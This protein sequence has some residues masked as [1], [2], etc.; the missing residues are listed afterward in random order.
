M[1]IAGFDYEPTR[2]IAR[3]DNNVGAC[4]MIKFRDGRRFIVLDWVRT[5]DGDIPKEVIQIDLSRLSEIGYSYAEFPDC[6]YSLNGQ[7]TLKD[8]RPLPE[9]L[10]Q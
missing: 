7:L 6:R 2:I 8:A 3:I 9:D 1:D 10:S 5:H 4:D